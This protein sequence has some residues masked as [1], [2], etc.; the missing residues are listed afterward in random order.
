M[1]FW[2]EPAAARAKAS[3][4]IDGGGG[5]RCMHL[6]M[7]GFFKYGNFLLENFKWCSLASA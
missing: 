5:E 1:V 7:L 2:L 3:R 6:S 4:L